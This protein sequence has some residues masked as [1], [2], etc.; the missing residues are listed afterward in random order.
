MVIPGATTRNPD[1]NLLLLGL[2]I[3]LMFCH[4]MIIAMTV[5]FPDPVAI[6]SAHRISC[7][8]A[9]RFTFCRWFRNLLPSCPSFGATSVSH[10]IVSTASSWQK[11]GL[12]S[13]NW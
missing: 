13:W 8:F 10:M 9:S 11:N 6:L 4:A 3:A 7:G 1:V 2:R 12:I 5:V